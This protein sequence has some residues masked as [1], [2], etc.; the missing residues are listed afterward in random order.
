LVATDIKNKSACI[1]L[2]LRKD[3]AVGTESH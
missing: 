3:K 1:L 2:L